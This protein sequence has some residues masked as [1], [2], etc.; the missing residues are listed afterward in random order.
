MGK[1]LKKNPL[2]T[3]SDTD[4]GYVLNHSTLENNELALVVWIE[5][6]LS[7]CVMDFLVIL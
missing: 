6:F 1:R 3:V 4:G 7:N 5:L 2:I